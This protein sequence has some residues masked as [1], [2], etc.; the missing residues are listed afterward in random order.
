MFFQVIS[1]AKNR[2]EQDRMS[3]MPNETS[4]VGASKA[5]PFPVA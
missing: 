3:A 5:F 2:E 4:V 1:H